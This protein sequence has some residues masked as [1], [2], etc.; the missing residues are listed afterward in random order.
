[1]VRPQHLLLSCSTILFRVLQMAG[2]CSHLSYV[3]AELAAMRSLYAAVQLLISRLLD[4]V[5]QMQKASTAESESSAASMSRDR[6]SGV[7]PV[8][9]ICSQE[10]HTPHCGCAVEGQLAPALTW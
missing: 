10:Q 1:M 5:I 6:A 2:R 4:F 3:P 9:M 8:I 7:V